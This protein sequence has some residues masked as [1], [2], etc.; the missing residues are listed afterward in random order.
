MVGGLVA[1]QSVE[2]EVPVHFSNEDAAPG[3]KQNSGT[4][5]VVHHTVA[6]EVAPESIPD[7]ITVDLTG[8]NIG[9]TIHVSDLPVPAG[10]T[11]DIPVSCVEQGRWRV[12]GNESV[13][14]FSAN[15]ATISSKHFARRQPTAIGRKVE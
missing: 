5:N 9:D 14:E 15:N 8:R 12:R 1:G 3:I 11:I 2:V 4:L 6:V 13:K 7:A 10:A